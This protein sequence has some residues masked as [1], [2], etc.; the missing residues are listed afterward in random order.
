MFQNL[1]EASG[2]HV[3]L[4][5]LTGKQVVVPGSHF[6]HKVLQG[7]DLH[8]YPGVSVLRVQRVNVLIP[9]H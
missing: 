2:E 4:L 7:F 6:N 9:S 3:P 8:V 5:Q 1:P